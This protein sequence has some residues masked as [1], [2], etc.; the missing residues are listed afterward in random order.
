MMSVIINEFEVVADRP[1]EEAGGG[2]VSAA[3]QAAESMPAATEPLSPQDIR[4]VLH[5][6]WVRQERV[7]AD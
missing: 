5:H 6:E 3:S 2:T 4:N 1:Q 7:R